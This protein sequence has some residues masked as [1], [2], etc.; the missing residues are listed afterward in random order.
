M[1]K[2]AVL[3]TMLYAITICGMENQ[4]SFEP[5]SSTQKDRMTITK[6]NKKGSLEVICGPMFSGKSEELIRR[7]RRAAIAK[8]T[9]IT[10]KHIWD[11][12]HDTEKVRSHNG[13]TYDAYA[14][15]NTG[16]IRLLALKPDIAVVGI[17]EVQFYPPNEIIDTINTLINAG[18]KVIVA[19]LDLDFRAMPFGPMP[20]LLAIAKSVHKLS[21]ICTVCDADDAHLSQ[22]LI[23]S[24]PAKFD[25][26][27]VMVGAEDTYQARCYNCYEI[28]KRPNYCI[29]PDHLTINQNEQ[30]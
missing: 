28:D 22:R 5:D 30:K 12:R 20:T 15:A 1:K 14:T 17:D 27:I 26:P 18:K 24:K 23:N 2:T 21:A 6:N 29:T 25:D 19:G 11:D 7:L 8:Q 9:V 13:T 10:F 4:V 16:F 3:S